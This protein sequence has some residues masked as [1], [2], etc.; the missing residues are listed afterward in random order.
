[1]CCSPDI[2]VGLSIWI[3]QGLSDEFVRLIRILFM[4]RVGG[5]R[6]VWLSMELREH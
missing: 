4:C 5:D 1:M 6:G 3:V 2:R